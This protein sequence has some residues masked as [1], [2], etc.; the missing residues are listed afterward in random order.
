[1]WGTDR[2]TASSGGAPSA[3]GQ[4]WRTLHEHKPES[5]EH[6]VDCERSHGCFS[7]AKCA[8]GLYLMIQPFCTFDNFA[9]RRL[10]CSCSLHYTQFIHSLFHSLSLSSFQKKWGPHNYAQAGYLTTPIHLALALTKCPHP[11]PRLFTSVCTSISL[12]EQA[13]KS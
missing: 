6:A 2:P 5:N 12:S 8:L 4:W 9:R 11:F 1:M 3:S 7:R 13:E 10:S